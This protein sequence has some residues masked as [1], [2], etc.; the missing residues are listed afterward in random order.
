MLSPKKYTKNADPSQ[1][2]WQ[3]FIHTVDH[4]NVMTLKFCEKVLSLVCILKHGDYSW[5]PVP[6]IFV[7]PRNFLHTNICSI[8][9]VHNVYLFEEEFLSILAFHK[10]ALSNIGHSF[11]W[12]LNMHV[13]APSFYCW[14]WYSVV[15]QEYGLEKPLAPAVVVFKSTEKVHFCLILLFLLWKNLEL[16][17]DRLPPGANGPNLFVQ[18]ELEIVIFSWNLQHWQTGWCYQVHYLPALLCCVVG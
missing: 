7:N 16:K 18:I 13:W 8:R 11:R 12:I 9:L 15:V 2:C 4:K 5:R 14:V 6:K 1:T 10:D 3:T 17:A